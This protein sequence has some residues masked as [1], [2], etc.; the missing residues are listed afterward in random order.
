MVNP[1]AKRIQTLVN[2]HG[3]TI[4]YEQGDVSETGGN[5]D[6]ET[7]GFL[8]G[9]EPTITSTTVKASVRR[10]KVQELTDLIQD[11]D[12]RVRISPLDLDPIQPKENDT[13]IIDTDRF[14][15]KSMHIAYNKEDRVEY[16]LQV[17][18]KTS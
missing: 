17:R 15:V 4:T 16:I 14:E 6:P 3:K 18:G 12:R 5:F 1:V 10:F 13:V 9:N 8:P 2:K 11:G 7:G